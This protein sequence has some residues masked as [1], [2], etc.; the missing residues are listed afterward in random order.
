MQRVHK[1]WYDARMQPPAD[2][3]RWTQEEVTLLARKEAE[4]T[5]QHTPPR[6]MNQELLSHFPQRT[7]EALKG[8]RRRADYKSLVATYMEE[9]EAAMNDT[10]PSAQDQHG[11]DEEPVDDVFLEF[12]E[13]LPPLREGDFKASHLQRII[14]NARTY[15]K[16]ATLQRL[17]LY[18]GEIFP[19]PTSGGKKKGGQGV[20]HAQDKKREA[21]RRA[22]AFTQNLWKKNRRRCIISILD[23]LDDVA[24]PP[25]EVMEPYWRTIMRTVSRDAPAGTGVPEIDCIWVPISSGDL[26]WGRVVATTG[27]GPDGISA[28]LLRAIPAGILVRIYNVLMWCGRLPE[29]LLKSRTVFLPK[30]AGAS[31]PGDFRPITIPSV[32][33]RGLHKILAKRVEAALDIDQRQRA[34]R[35]TD[36]CA[37]NTFL[38]DTI[39]RYHRKKYRSVYIASLDVSKAFDS[40]S[41]HAIIVALRNMGFPSPMVQYLE[42]VYARSKTRLE[43]GTWTSSYVHPERG[44]RQGDPLS[45]II[46]NALTHQMLRL[47]PREIGVHI[48]DT[49]VNAAAFADDLLLFASTPTGLQTSIDI[50]SGYLGNCGMKINVTKSMTISIVANPHAKKTAVDAAKVFKCEGERLPTGSRSTRWRY[51]GVYFTPEGRAQCRPA[52]LLRPMLDGLGRAPLKPQQ[53]VFALRAAVLPRLYYQLALGAVTLGT[54][55][56]IDKLVRSA[57]R[58][59]LALPHDVPVAFIHAAIRDGGLGV[60]SVR[61]ISPLQRRGRIIAAKRTHYQRGFDEFAENELAQCERRLTDHGTLYSTP[62][63]INDRWRDQLFGT[64]DGAGLRESRGTPHQHQWVADGNR[65]L[66]GKDYINCIRMRISAMPTR[67]RLSRGRLRDRRCR[68]GCLAQETLNHV[69]QQCHRT[70]GQRIKR[71]DAVL[72][73]MERRIRNGGYKIFREPHYKTA[74]GLRKPDLVAVL[75]ETAVVVDAQVVGEQANLNQAHGKKIAY[76]GREAVVEAIKRT[77]GVR[78]VLIQSATMSWKGVWSSESAEQLRRLGF[79]VT[80]DL[81]ILSTRVLIGGI[82]EYR[83]FNAST[84]I[85][86][87][88]GIG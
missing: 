13:S 2:K 61:W 52:E 63:M 39:L 42:D 35:N 19:Q 16:E 5:S 48:G 68:A 77:H 58:R 29:R 51:L 62:E 36:G 72:G 9:L 3:T 43:G 6:F 18:L 70:H 85:G 76:Y 40:V 81:K 10:P 84:M 7:L 34:F 24:Q 57:V 71:H 31:E 74:D 8:R 1:D 32:L 50:V 53:R 17:T 11:V 67:S 38:L 49:T 87:R 88:T 47:L 41:H 78:E 4:L 45:P 14:A 37:D 75:G 20:L 66:S 21:R 33:I 44:V 73:Y 86:R 46:F 64:V 27:A 54:L 79:V 30:M 59:W 80:G 28:R 12:L 26:K 22:Y 56:K 82:A 65:L 60:P 23:N 69:L 25:R 55:K 15:G 83:V